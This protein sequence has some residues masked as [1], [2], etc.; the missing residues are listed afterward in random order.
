MIIVSTTR[1]YSLKIYYDMIPSMIGT[2]N[3]HRHVISD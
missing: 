1:P 2:E 3:Q